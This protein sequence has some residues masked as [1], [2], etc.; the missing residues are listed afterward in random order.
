MRF[1]FAD[2]AYWV[3]LTNPRDALHRQAIKIPESLG[4][5]RVITSEMVLV[6]LLNVVSGH[7]SHLRRS[8]TGLVQRII[9]DPYIELVPQT[10]PL[11]QDALALYRDR[12]DKAW[13]LTDCASFLIMDERAITE[14]LTHDQHYVQNGYHALLRE[15]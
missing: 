3:A 11:F 12:S 4:E 7:G 15:R 8:A 5:Y 14:A 2:T 9:D 13:S 10:T 6:E 1:I